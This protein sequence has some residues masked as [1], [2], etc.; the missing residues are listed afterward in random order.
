[1]IYLSC[2]IKRRKEGRKERRKKKERK[3]KMERNTFDSN[4]TESLCLE[5]HRILLL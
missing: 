4:L 5:A 2:L 1:M 3:K